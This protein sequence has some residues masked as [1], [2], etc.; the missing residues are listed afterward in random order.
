[1]KKI[2]SLIMASLMVVSVMFMLVG[3]AGEGGENVTEN[4][5]NNTNI[6]DEVKSEH[7][8][9]A[10]IDGK[11]FE[12][13]CTLKELDELGLALLYEHDLENLRAATNEHFGMVISNRTDFNLIYGMEAGDAPSKGDEN[14]N[15]TGII[16]N[17]ATKEQFSLNGDVYIGISIDD[18][19]A[20]L[21]DDYSIVGAV[22][23]DNIYLDATKINYVNDTEYIIVGAIDGV[24]NYI[25]YGYDW[26][27]D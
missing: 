1:M 17:K 15:V 7:L 11:D 9:T 10:K 12:F 20:S 3:C 5:D 4:K 16:T 21:G 23:P 6:L 8:C 19:I 27:E 24:V 18:A 14:I 2:F 22:N 26:S 25:E 13:P